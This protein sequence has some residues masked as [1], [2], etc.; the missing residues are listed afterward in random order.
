MSITATE[1][2]Q[3]I[4]INLG[5]VDVDG[6]KFTQNYKFLWIKLAHSKMATLLNKTII[7][8]SETLTIENNDGSDSVDIYIDVLDSYVFFATAQGKIYDK[9]F[10][11]AE[12]VWLAQFYNSI[13]EANETY[14]SKSADWTANV[15][16][17]NPFEECALRVGINLNEPAVSGTRFSDGTKFHWF[18]EAHRV[19]ENLLNKSV[20]DE[21][22]ITTFVWNPDDSGLVNQGV[23]DEERPV[24]Q[25]NIYDI[26]RDG[27]VMYA[28]YLGKLLSGVAE[29]AV[30]VWDANF[31]FYIQSINERLKTDITVDISSTFAQYCL[32]VGINLGEP[33]V[34]GEKFSSIAKSYWLEDAV[35]KINTL[36]SENVKS[37]SSPTSLSVS[38]TNISIT[39][40]EEYLDLYVMYATYLGKLSANEAEIAEKVWLKQ[41]YLRMQELNERYFHDD[42]TTSNSDSFTTVSDILLAIGINLGEPQ[43][44]GTKFSKLM[45]LHWITLAQNKL[46]TILPQGL[47]INHYAHSLLDLEDDI[48]EYSLASIPFNYITNIGLIYSSSNTDETYRKAL[49]VSESDFND[50]RNAYFGSENG[51]IDDTYKASVLTRVVNTYTDNTVPG[52]SV[53]ATKDYPIYCISEGVSGAV[54]I[55][56]SYKIKI[57]PEPGEDVTN[58]MKVSYYSFL[59]TVNYSSSQTNYLDLHLMFIE[60]ILQYATCLGKRVD[61]DLRASEMWMRDFYKSAEEIKRKFIGKIS[62]GIITQS[63][64]D[65]SLR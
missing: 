24:Q 9:D 47:S 62:T 48:I 46:A 42:S 35:A 38:G 65:N 56:Y 6:D 5:E 31:K 16:T 44:N 19:I 13:K 55:P 7:V 60:C 54:D 2:Y 18:E 1:V 23:M 8:N 36:L 43:I 28:T 14:L 49:R 11:V 25:L 4:G 52:T 51:E 64:A 32:K 59:S 58:G 57:F 26:A 50:I 21:S 40:Y 37:L 29:E 53:F 27:Y 10:E 15:L 17:N 63:K 20:K 34:D 45:K 39:W 61:K 33:V 3:L 22:A 30:K 12:K 41:F